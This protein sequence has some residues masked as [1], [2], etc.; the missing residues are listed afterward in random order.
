VCLELV[1]NI[2]SIVKAQCR[3]EMMRRPRKMKDPARWE[4]KYVTVAQYVRVFV[5]WT[6]QMTA[7]GY[8]KF[9][10]QN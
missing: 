1:R 7:F 5:V 4:K 9:A 2:N 6:N 8:L 3:D 10:P